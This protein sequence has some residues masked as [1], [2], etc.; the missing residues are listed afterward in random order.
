MRGVAV[1]AIKPEVGDHDNA[2]FKGES[3]GCFG[4]PVLA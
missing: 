4:T 2:V 1:R 3:E